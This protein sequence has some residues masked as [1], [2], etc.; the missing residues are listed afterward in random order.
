MK[1]SF[2]GA[3]LLACTIALSSCATS[4]NY[5]T[6]QNVNQT[7]VV[8][9]EANYKVVGKAEGN[10]KSRYI[11][12]IGGMSKKSMQQNAYSDMV[13][14]AKL[15]GSQ[16]LINI[17]YSQKVKSVPFYLMRSMKVEGTIIEFT[18]TLSQQVCKCK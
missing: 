12:G 2:I 15:T 16:A 11:F 3:L 14:N 6:N 7:N 4:G 18:K 1:K 9:S 17:N 13:Q 10:A 8:L 5:L